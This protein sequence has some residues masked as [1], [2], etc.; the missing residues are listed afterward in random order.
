MLAIVRPDSWNV[1]LFIHV[2]GAMAMVATLILAIFAIGRARRSGNPATAAFAFRVLWM[3]VLPAYIAM[4]VGGQLIDDKEK[5]SDTTWLDV[6]FMVG[7]GGALLLIIALILTGLGARRAKGGQPAAAGLS[8]A[9]G[10]GALLLALSVVA[11]FAMTA[12]PG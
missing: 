2:A 5:L 10:L 9:A 11:I 7:D 1:F 4:R 12:K 3:A 6:G 8:V